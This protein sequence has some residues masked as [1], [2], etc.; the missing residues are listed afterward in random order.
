[1]KINTK[2][3]L[4]VKSKLKLTCI[5][6]NEG[7]GQLLVMANEGNFVSFEPDRFK[8]YRTQHVNGSKTAGW[9]IAVQWSETK[10]QIHRITFDKD[11]P[12]IE[13]L[14]KLEKYAKTKEFWKENK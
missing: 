2:T 8:V 10:T 11:R 6:H 3:W 7:N 14:K 9:R 13:E 12:I 1:M 4:K 5:S